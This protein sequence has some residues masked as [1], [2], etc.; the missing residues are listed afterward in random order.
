MSL[1][2]RTV[3]S[4][5]N[6]SFLG[7]TLREGLP[8]ATLSCVSG[9]LPQPFIGDLRLASIYVLSL[10]PGLQPSD[11]YGEYAVPEYRNAFLANLKQQFHEKA[12]PFIFLDPHYST[13]P[14]IVVS[15]GG[16]GNYR[17]C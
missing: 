16:T 2:S 17:R 4:D 8:L 11:Y 6:Q 7:C 10:N 14:G 15:G 3:G 9:L 5:L 1:A 12:P 13:T